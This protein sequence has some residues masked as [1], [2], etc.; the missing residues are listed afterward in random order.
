MLM[1][2]SASGL[3]RLSGGRIVKALDPTMNI[4]LDT[5]V[6]AP[7]RGEGTSGDGAPAVYD[8]TD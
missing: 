4:L 7:R 8:T 6:P 3:A 1:Q 5:D 2:H